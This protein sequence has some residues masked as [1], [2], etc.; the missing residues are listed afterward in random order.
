MAIA[1]LQF[2]ALAIDGINYLPRSIDIAAHLEAG[3]LLSTISDS[4]ITLERASKAKALILIRHHLETP[5]KIQCLHI[6]DPKDL[7]E[8]LKTRFNNQKLVF[9]PRARYD[10]LNLRVQDFPSLVAYN[11]EL[12]RITSELALFGEPISEANQIEKTLSTFHPTNLILASQYRNMKFQMYSDLISYMLVTKKHQ[13]LLLKNSK[14]CPLGILPTP[15]PPKETYF[16]SQ[17]KFKGRFGNQG[18]GGFN[19]R[20][21]RGFFQQGKNRQQF[22][23]RFGTKTGPQNRFLRHTSNKSQ[24]RFQNSQGNSQGYNSNFQNRRPYRGNNKK[25]NQI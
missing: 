11:N 15:T 22:G 18:S 20:K 14:V 6:N 8:A 25:T 24:K 7:W 9:L 1:K 23:P 12:F 2:S 17:P 16:V 10:W 5:L 4:L 19:N 21:G 3:G 13:E